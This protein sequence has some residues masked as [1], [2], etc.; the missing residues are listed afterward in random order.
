MNFTIDNLIGLA[1]SQIWQVTLLLA[2]VAVAT[3]VVCRRRPHLAYMLWV[4]VVLKCL[5]PPLWSSPVGCFSWAQCRVEHAESAAAGN[6]VAATTAASENVRPEPVVP[7]VLHEPRAEDSYEVVTSDRLPETAAAELPTASGRNRVSFAAIV[8]ACWIAGSLGLAGLMGWKWLGYRRVLRHSA[9]ATVAAIERRT[10]QLAEQLGLRRKVRVVVTSE[11]IGPAVFGLLRPVIVLPEALVAGTLRAASGEAESAGRH[12]ECACYDQ[13]YMEPILAHELVHI[14]RGDIYWGTIQLAAEVLWWFHPLVWWANRETCRQRERCCDEEVVAGLKCRPAAYARCLLDV[15][16]LERKWQPTLA[17]TA[18]QSQ[19]DT[20]KRLENIMKRSHA[21]HAKTPRWSWAVLLLAAVLVLP[22]K[23]LVLDGQEPQVEQKTSKVVVAVA[24]VNHAAHCL[25]FSP[26]S[27]MV[28]GGM[29][30]GSLAFW[31]AADGSETRVAV[32]TGEP[33]VQAIL[34]LP[35]GEEVLTAGRKIKRWNAKT[36]QLVETIDLEGSDTFQRRA[37][38][39]DG[40]YLAGAC[41]RRL[42]LWDAKTGR[43]KHE[44]SLMGYG[45]ATAF[46][47][48]G[49]LLAI[50]TTVPMGDKECKSGVQIWD[51]KTGE[52]KRTILEPTGTVSG[53]AFSHDCQQL[54]GG[55]HREVIVWDADS[56]AVRKRLPGFHG[57]VESVAFSPDDA[58]L[59]AGGQGPESQ[60]HNELTI[61]SELNVWKATGEK[62]LSHTGSRLRFTSVVFSHDGKQIAAC[63]YREVVVFGLDQWKQ[64]WG[65]SYEIETVTDTGPEPIGFAVRSREIKTTDASDSPSAMPTVRPQSQ[66][67]GRT[68]MKGPHTTITGQVVD[69]AGKGI[70][71]AQVAAVGYTRTRSPDDLLADRLKLWGTA[72]ADAEG[73]FQLDLPMLSSAG[74]YEA[75]LAAKADGCNIGLK[76]IGLD[77]AAPQ[78]TIKLAKEETIRGQVL[79]GEGKPVADAKV[80][81]ASFGEPRPGGFEGIQCWR[82]PSQVPFWPKPATTD[83]DG[84]FTLRGVDRSQILNVQ[85]RDDRFAINWFQIGEAGEKDPEHEGRVK[86]SSSG[87]VTLSPPPARIFEGRVTYEDTH[88]PV[89]NTRVMVGSSFDPF[90]CIMNVAAKTDADGRFRVNTYSGKVFF[91]TA[92]PPDG[93]PYLRNEKE[94]KLADGQRPPKVEIALPRAVML[95]GKITEKSSGE[96]VGGAEIK[97]EELNE[98]PFRPD[99][100]LPDHAAPSLEGRSRSD[101]AYEM[102][103]P[104]GR[105]VLLVQGPQNDYIRQTITTRD[106]DKKAVRARRHYVG[107]FTTLDLKPDQPSAEVDLTLRRGVTLKGRIVGP[108]DQPPGDVLILS[109]HFIGAGEDEFRGGHITAKDGQFALHGLDPE[110]ATPFYFLDPK[111]ETGATVEISG[112]SADAGPLVVRL[113]PCGK[114]VARFVNFGGTPKADY[115]TSLQILVSPGPFKGDDK[116]SKKEISSDQDYVANFDRDHYWHQPKTDADGRCVFP[117]LIPGATYRLPIFNKLGDW[118]EKDFTVKSGETLQLPDIADKEKKPA[119]G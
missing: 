94:I 59:A 15:L 86:V 80:C 111:N 81:V 118:D 11:P 25:A 108:N 55:T 20:S 91:V 103:V 44:L 53:L 70:G 34:L 45:L 5:T 65:K 8:A 9:V 31:Q 89:A 83:R 51:V 110:K 79:D 24:A 115:Q 50:G 26:D 48:D 109:R 82:P 96:P 99:R 69:S 72:T 29:Y 16:E 92:C 114:A 2:I 57:P 37:F 64:I 101:G 32:A 42:L 27:R 52:L 61:K 117:A 17:V 119:P 97:Y 93:K 3:R 106:F 49:R 54:A 87:E 84:R 77:V 73:R 88:Q 41:Q 56:G 40:A 95:R 12:T 13:R 6:D 35:S 90:R 60:T 112:K 100:I 75:H 39:G 21:F 62:L 4:L 85:V 116:R 63:D 58:M 28:I 18:M 68:D 23:A 107:G 36:G 43:K 102:A 19:K 7:E 14:R 66:K 22:G 33:W 47:P 30:D 105:G 113:A 98:P 76:T 1:W 67:P 46:S 10:A 38:S 78:M 71:G 104:P 74:Y